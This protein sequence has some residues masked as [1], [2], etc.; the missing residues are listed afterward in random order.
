MFL[1]EATASVVDQMGVSPEIAG[2]ILGVVTSIPELVS[3][4]AIYAASKR[5]GKSQSLND[6]QEA[7][8]NLT[9]GVS[10]HALLPDASHSACP[11]AA[12]ESTVQRATPFA[13]AVPAPRGAPRG[14]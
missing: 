4:F 7:L 8:D 6:T 12:C 1:G 9:G 13:R 14:L 5:A 3:F 2:W 11:L 10:A